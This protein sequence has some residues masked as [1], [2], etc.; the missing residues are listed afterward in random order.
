MISSSTWKGS[1]AVKVEHVVLEVGGDRHDVTGAE[2]LGV[3]ES[4]VADLEGR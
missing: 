1:N 2:Q 3:H 4:D